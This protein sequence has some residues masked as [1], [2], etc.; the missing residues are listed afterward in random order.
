VKCFGVITEMP[1]SF[2]NNLIML[3]HERCSM[4]IFFLSKKKIFFSEQPVLRQGNGWRKSQVQWSKRPVNNNVVFPLLFTNYRPTHREITWANATFQTLQQ[5]LWQVYLNVW[6]F[7]VY[8]AYLLIFKDTSARIAWKAFIKFGKHT[9]SYYAYIV[10]TK[11]PI[12]T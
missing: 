3:K 5:S 6:F 11:L 12:I 2:S 7:V 10:T 8:Y 1:F 9:L 4:Q